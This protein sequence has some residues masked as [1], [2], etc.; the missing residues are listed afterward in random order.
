[1]KA[2]NAHLEYTLEITAHTHTH[3]HSHLGARVDL[4]MH[5]LTSHES[6]V[7]LRVRPETCGLSGLNF[8]CFQYNMH[9]EK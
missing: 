2:G 1:M 4:N 5:A 8:T 3:I 9:K 6:S 7:P